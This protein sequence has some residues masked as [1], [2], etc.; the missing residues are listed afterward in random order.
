[1]AE[2]EPVRRDADAERELDEQAG[3]A[4]LAGRYRPRDPSGRTAAATAF[5]HSGPTAPAVRPAGSRAPRRA[6]EAA[7][8]ADP[9]ARHS[10]R[11]VG[12]RN[13]TGRV[14]AL[15]V[16]PRDPTVL[17]AGTAS[18]GVFRSS[19]G[20][21]SW[22][23]LWHDQP[24]LAVGALGVAAASPAAPAR[25]RVYAATGEIVENGY[26][27]AGHG[28]WVSDDAGASW[29]DHATTPAP[30][31]DTHHGFDALAVDP[32]DDDHC[33]AVGAGG[34]FRTVDGGRTWQTHL[35]GT[36]FSDVVFSDGRLYLAR[37]RSAA[38]EAAVLRLDPPTSTRAAS[39]AD[40]SAALAAADALSTVVGPLPADAP[41]PARTKL[42]VAPSAPDIAYARV[43]TDDDRHLG[44]FRCRN[45]RATP[46]RTMAW[47]RLADHHDFV[48]EGQGQFNL[49]IAVS[50]TDPGLVATGMVDLHVSDVAD[51]ADPAAVRWRRAIS[52]E[53]WTA[54]RGHH[55]DQHA[56]V[57]TAA[58]DLLV[59]NDGG[60]VRSSDWATG[61]EVARQLPLDVGAI[62][63]RR[64]D[65]GIA[66]GQPYDLNQSSLLP[67][68]AGAGFQ[69]TGVQLGAGGRTWRLVSGAD[70]GFV[71]FDP[72]D[73]FRFVLTDQLGVAAAQFPGLLDR[74]RPAGPPLRPRRLDDGFSARDPAGFVADTDRHRVRGDRLLTARRNRV[75][76]SRGA[77][78]ERWDIEDVGTS[79]EIVGQSLQILPTP[80]AVKLGLLPGRAVLGSVESRLP[81]PYRLTAGDQVRIQIGAAVHVATFA[82]GT[83]ADF[84]AVTLA[85]VLRVL[86]GAAPPLPP[87]TVL[88]RM[89]PM[90]RAVELS[91]RGLDPDHRIELA[92]TLLDPTADGLSRLGVNRGTYRGDDGRPASLTLGFDGYDLSERARNRDLS[93][94]GTLSV[95]VNGG[96]ARPVDLSGVADPAQVTAGELE[97]A[98]RAALAPDAD[99][100]DVIATTPYK[101]V[102]LLAAPGR[103][104]RVTGTAA[105]RLGVPPTSQPIAFLAGPE[106]GRGGRARRRNFATVDL[107]PS[108]AAPLE[109]EI[110]DGTTSTGPLPF[111]AADVADLH[112]VTVEEL[113]RVVRRRLAATAGITVTADLVC[114]VHSEQATAVAFSSTRPDEA[115]VGGADGRVFRTVDDGATW[116]PDGSEAMRLADARVEAIVPHPGDPEVAYVGLWRPEAGPATLPLLFRY[117]G[118]P[119]APGWAAIGTALDGTGVAADGAPRP[120][121]A[122]ALDPADPRVVFAA[123]D[124]G[125]FRSRDAG[126]TWAPF[127]E[128]LPHCRVIDLAVVPATRSLRAA[129]WGRGVWERALGP[130]PPDEVSLVVRSTDLDDGSAA[131]RRGPTLFAAA[132][133]P[134][135]G[136]SPDLVHLRR[137]PG[138]IGPDPGV[139]GVVF[140]LEL[141]SDEVVAGQ[142]GEVLVQVSNRGAFPARSSAAAPPPPAPDASVAVTL[143]WA[144]VLDAPPPLPL[145]FWGRYKAGTVG[146]AEGA[147]TRIA[148][149]R[150]PAAVT[151]ADPA[152][153][154]APVAWPDPL[155]TPAIAVLAL[156]TATDDVLDGGPTDVGELVTAERRA[157]LRCFPVRRAADDRTLLLRATGPER[158][159][160]GDRPGLPTAMTGR[161]GITLAQ[162]GVLT[163]S[164]LADPAAGATYDLSGVEPGLLIER[165]PVDV[166]IVVDNTLG[167]FAVLT[168]V[169]AAETAAYVD[170]RLQQ[171]GLPVEATEVDAGIVISGLEGATVRVTGGSAAARLGLAVGGAPSAQ[172]V[173]GSLTGFDLR[174]DL[175]LQLEVTAQGTHAL[176]VT[177][178]STAFVDPEHAAPSRVALLLSRAIAGAHLE[179]VL[180]CAAFGGISIGALGA[181]EGRASRD[182]EVAVAGDAAARLG[183]VGPPGPLQRA[184]PFVPG[185]V[186]LSGPAGAPLHLVVTVTHRVVVRFDRDPDLIPDLAAAA[187]PDVRRAIT[188][189]CAQEGMPVRAE[190]PFAALSLRASAAEG[191]AGA[192]TGGG[193]LAEVAT[194]GAAAA[195]D[196]DALF[197]VRRAL[198]DDRLAAGVANHVY[199]RVRNAGNVDAAPAR[200]RLLRL[201]PT[202]TP[203]TWA[204]AADATGP[205]PAE[206]VAIIDV[207]HTPTAAAGGFEH[208]LAVADRDL[209]G[210]RVDVP[211]T[212]PD[213]DAVV[214]YAESRPDVALRTLGVGP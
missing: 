101:A 214:V 175:D 162:V 127:N 84:G 158:F 46:A 138:S 145:D 129:L 154:G 7:G 188:R 59:A 164:L 42:A 56:A 134:D 37:A 104:V 205:V 6:A 107:T 124:A 151:P 31:P 161:L 115:W 13:V 64:C 200:V 168:D 40:V 206:G 65:E 95:A 4:E 99:H 170:A 61:A 25:R 150:L 18:G 197:D 86:R 12:P 81:A 183:L 119:P 27:V 213:L 156:V 174:G 29:S 45:A 109:L 35:P 122:L 72:D 33:W 196:P 36:A 85:E 203:V 166:D 100:V 155:P 69:D 208:L 178:P 163:R 90:A 22:T 16:D 87:R 10:W 199:V 177:L 50:P 113:H 57:V 149:L 24:S 135:P 77:R 1:M 97:A 17:Y 39:Q 11:P 71:S 146:A 32:A 67:T 47:Q 76:G 94:G 82:A 212:F 152:V 165:E 195:A 187:P 19:D 73:P 114:G 74:V 182:V 62:T 103:W 142:A 120:V 181:A 108:G 41:W 60:I 3:R 193:R 78:G 128:G 118:T 88:P 105:E 132:P 112:A 180:S 63:W 210:A 173:A 14:R 75:Y 116:T 201:D 131:S 160:V 21:G 43:V 191:R 198:A 140:D 192:R 143:L 53:L 133:A 106:T 34:V 204:A 185:P 136:D 190:I 121:H 211:A 159:L 70:G 123:T 48:A 202:A 66:G 130:Q 58:G 153:I 98:L 55:A 209:D 80:G 111:T 144:P 176:A 5:G 148:V 147:W 126:D 194:S 171:S 38:G 28:I 172:L 117:R 186:D 139:D 207:A 49:C 9:T 167:E 79:F 96:A 102:L 30:N 92:G 141:D 15:A 93:G 2:V 20:G 91:T 184:S 189:A 51:A 137:R 68:V 89:W 8:V 54:V 52:W 44:V 157:A 125:V 179:G 23:P 169:T 83:V 26:G 110:S